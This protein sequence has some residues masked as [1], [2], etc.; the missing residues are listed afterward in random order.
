MERHGRDQAAEAG[1]VIVTVFR[2]WLYLAL[3]VLIVVVGVS[4]DRGSRA[5]ELTLQHTDQALSDV[6]AIEVNT[7]RTEA[8]LAGLLNSTRHIAETERA[9]AVQQSKSIQELIGHADQVLQDVDHTVLAAGSDEA[10]LQQL[11]VQSTA[12]INNI[13]Q[14]THT[15]LVNAAAT[16]DPAPIQASLANVVQSTEH[17]NQA[18]QDAAATM[19]DV[20]K[21]VEYEL[22]ELTKP[23]KKV[24]VVGEEAVRILG[25][26]LGY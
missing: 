24:K 18:T 15:V 9:A 11:L 26:F 1:I 13:T 14:D 8:E 2:C 20:R 12:S 4:V 5:W 17:I 25:K 10:Q 22:G 19:V 6:H 21:G 3:I 16:L 7:T 23:V